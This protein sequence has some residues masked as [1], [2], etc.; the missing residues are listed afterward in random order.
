MFEKLLQLIKNLFLGKK[1]TNTSSNIINLTTTTTTL[2]P[3]IMITQSTIQHLIDWESKRYKAYD[4]GAGYMTIGVGHAIFDKNEK[5]EN[6]LLLTSTLTDEEV[7]KLLM[8]DLSS[9]VK[10]DQQIKDKITHLLTQNQYDALVLFIFNTGRLWNVLAGTI[11]L[12]L[13]DHTKHENSLKKQWRYYNFANGKTM[14]GLINRREGELELF[15]NQYKGRDYYTKSKTVNGKI[16][17][18]YYS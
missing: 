12:Y 7:E 16:E 5:F 11:N 15:L 1:D 13:T 6:K 9:R 8:Q 4:D 10:A 2:Q 17:N 3:M 18:P 14:A